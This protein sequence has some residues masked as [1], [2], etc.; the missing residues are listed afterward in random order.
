MHYISYLPSM[1]LISRCWGRLCENIKTCSK[2]N[3]L[4][5]I[6]FNTFRLSI[7]MIKWLIYGVPHPVSSMISF[8]G[9]L[10]FLTNIRPERTANT[11]P[12]KRVCTVSIIDASSTIIRC[13]TTDHTPR[14]NAVCASSLACNISCFIRDCNKEF[15]ALVW[16]LLIIVKRWRES[17]RYYLGNLAMSRSG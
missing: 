16:K 3:F 1:I 8:K 4:A 13:A 15:L 5:E 11:H 9:F 17:K 14:I 10:I 2:E 6:T 12:A 7:S